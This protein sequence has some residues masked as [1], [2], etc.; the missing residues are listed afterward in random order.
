VITVYEE[1]PF[2]LKQVK[3][4]TIALRYLENYA[5]SPQKIPPLLIFHGPSGVGKYFAAERFVKTVLCLEG[6][7]CGRC[8]SCRLF[9]KRNHP[10]FIEFP[11]RVSILIGD[12]SNPKEFTIRWLLNQKIVFSPL[13]S[14]R[15]FVLIPDATLL[16]NEAETAM[17]KTLEEAPDH[18][19]FL[20]LVENLKD[21][22]DTIVSRAVLIPFSFLPGDILAEIASEQKILLPEL[23]TGSFALSCIEPE[24]WKEYFDI[25][26]NTIHDS[27][28][29][30]QLESWILSHKTKASK[31]KVE[32]EFRKFL[33]IVTSLMIYTYGRDRKKNWEECIE[34]IYEC[35]EILHKEIPNMEGFA[36]SRMFYKLS[37][38][39]N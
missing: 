35:K 37:Q 8:S 25:V 26:N 11:E 19:R 15:R 16:T 4:Q 33:D 31:W 2:S 20:F 9:A 18:T 3:G 14:T 7:A 1:P 36:L 22:K 12:E 13:H 27:L 10:D 17:L 21:L 30:L 38:L 5:K 39:N 28:L 24:T 23:H 29:L 34:A 6:N 32:F